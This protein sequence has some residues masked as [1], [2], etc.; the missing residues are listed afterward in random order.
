MGILRYFR[1]I[2]FTSVQSVPNSAFADFFVVATLQLISSSEKLNQVLYFFFPDDFSQARSFSKISI[3][4]HYFLAILRL[5]FVFY[6]KSLEY[7]NI[8][9][10][11]FEEELSGCCVKVSVSSSKDS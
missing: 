11:V 1:K 6:S 4:T 3:L 2:S 5:F 9:H 7:H 8:S 10:S